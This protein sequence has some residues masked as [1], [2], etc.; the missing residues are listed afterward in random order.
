MVNTLITVIGALVLVLG[1][2]S[3]KLEKSALSPTL[4]ALIAGVLLGPQ[5][6]D[7][8]DLNELGGRAKFLETAARLTLGIGL[9]SVALRVPKEFVRRNW[10]SIFSFIGL[11]MAGMWLIS[12]AFV[13]LLLGVPFWMAALIGAILAPTDP[14]AATPIVTGSLAEKNIPESVRDSISFESGANDGLSYLFVF[15]PVL[16]ITKPPSDA[17]WHWMTHT[18]LWQVVAATL[19]GLALGFLAGWLLRLSEGRNLIGENWRLVYTAALGLIAIGGGKLIHT[20]E[21]LV[22]FAAGAA[23]TQIVSQEDRGKE[24]HGQEAVN[25]FFSIPMFA[26][27]GAAI[28][29]EGWFDLGW[30]GIALAAAVLLLRRIPVVLLL[31]GLLPGAQG[32]K[33]ALFVGWFGPIAVAA[34]YYASLTEH[35]LSEPIIWDV[36]S[37]VVCA[38]AIV[39]GLT[40]APLTRRYGLAKGRS[41]QGLAS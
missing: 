24:E 5:A 21:V 23:F 19:L 13:Y 12:S 22:V 28:P 17:F 16:M 34:V 25:R 14:V 37:L 3:K 10:R 36:V 39:H 11:G 2:A 8:L 27:L 20:D 33:D 7:I 35:R 9:V 38:S 32:P 41:Q 29:W 31:K 18:L 1:L 40:G 30:R 26:L 6:A 15:L 4:L